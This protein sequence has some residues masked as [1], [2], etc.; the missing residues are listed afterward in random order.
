MMNSPSFREDKNVEQNII[1]TVR[2]IFN[3]K[4]LKK[5]QQMMLQ[6]KI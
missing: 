6:L 1:N 3:L 4:K 5:K 2:N